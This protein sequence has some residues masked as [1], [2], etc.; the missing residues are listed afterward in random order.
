MSNSLYISDGKV[1]MD[2]EHLSQLV[3]MQPGDAA[4][5]GTQLMA[6]A[7]DLGVEVR[8]PVERKLSDQIRLKLYTRA[9][10]IIRSMHEKTPAQVGVHVVDEVLK[11]VM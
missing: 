8:V 7:A 10:H 11:E 5:L 6:M 2:F 4:R 9:A 1:V 3:T